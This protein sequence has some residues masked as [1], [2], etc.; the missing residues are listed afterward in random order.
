MTYYGHDADGVVVERTELSTTTYANW[1]AKVAGLLTEELDLE[2]GDA[3]RLDL[4]ATHWLAPVLWGATWSAGL[5]LLLGASTPIDD[6]DPASTV[7][8]CGPTTLPHW[9]ARLNA[10]RAVVASA[11]TPFARRFADGVPAGVVDLGVDV[12]GQPDAFISYDPPSGDDPALAGLTQAD[13]TVAGS[14]GRELVTDLGA[15]IEPVRRGAALL[16][17]GGSLVLVD[18][19]APRAAWWDARRA[20][21]EADERL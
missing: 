13:L 5:Q 19:R 1:V 15:D 18:D 9:S 4:G 17:G 11:L 2:R 16:L 10:H 3:V 20:V 21:I 12:W 8:V 6:V 14:D 7:V